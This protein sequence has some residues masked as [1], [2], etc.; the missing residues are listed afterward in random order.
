V[1]HAKFPLARAIAAL[2]LGG[3]GYKTAGHRVEF[4]LQE[5][6]MTILEHLR[7]LFAKIKLVFKNINIGNNSGTIGDNNG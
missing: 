5:N 6:K 7:K 3:Q 1:F 4:Y 2:P